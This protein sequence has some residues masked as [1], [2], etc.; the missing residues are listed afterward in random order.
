MSVSKTT[1]NGLSW[2]RY[3]LTTLAGFTGAIAI[4]PSNSSIVYAGGREESNAALYKTTNAGANWQSSSSGITSDTIYAIA[5]DPQNTSILYAGTPDGVFKST[6]SG[7]FWTNTGCSEI[8][9][10]L[11]DPNNTDIIYAGTRNGVYQSTTGG[12]GWTAMN[13]GLD[14]TY[15]TSLRFN[16]DVYIFAGTQ[17]NAMY[18]WALNVGVSEQKKEANENLVLSAQPNPTKGRTAIHYVLAKRT[19]VNLTIYDVQGRLV[20]ELVSDVQEPG[21]HVVFWDN[22]EKSSNPVSSGIYL[23]KL[24]T[25]NA[26][27]I[28]KLV[29]VK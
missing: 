11:I 25:D 18:R 3:D 28:Q 10:L 23:C 21:K 2:S 29:L 8:Q 17:G 7:T 9:A 26:T 4:D 22:V 16:P 24:S 27:V 20:S 19:M 1:N 12:G 5:I 15:V 13:D 6:N 14:N